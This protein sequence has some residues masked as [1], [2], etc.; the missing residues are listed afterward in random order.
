MA[1]KEK[2]VGASYEKRRYDLPL[3]RDAGTGFLTLLFALMTFLA[4]MALASSFVLSAMADRWTSGLEGRMTIELP[5]QDKDGNILSQTDLTAL[6]GRVEELLQS[7]PAVERVH[8]M[9]NGE[10]MDLV[11]PWI[12]SGMSLDNAPLPRLI[13]V[14]LKKNEEFNPQAMA[15]RIAAI[16]P[17][18]QLETH[19]SWLRDVLR[20]TGALQF[21]AAV[22][23]III[24][25]TSVTAV[26]GAIRSRMAVHREEVNLLHLMG[27]A[28]RYIA[29]QFQHHS[30]RLAFR[31]ALAGL[32]SGAFA[33]WLTGRIAGRM[34]IA[35]LPGFQMEP[36]HFAA[37]LAL[38]FAAAAIA[39]I[40][41][42]RTVRR[43]LEEMP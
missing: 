27:A 21:A 7:H 1:A 42:G 4:T 43:A 38:P 2:I 14:E 24:G 33:L 15:G 5:A 29:R 37:L 32:A 22:L 40:T 3:N 9:D 25:A 19:E 28:D 8:I 10:V 13:T 17:Q 20:F 41:A 30:L 23:T 36:W 39:A 31:G 6:A 16:A 35:L 34:N 11:K 26:A 12:G 18:A